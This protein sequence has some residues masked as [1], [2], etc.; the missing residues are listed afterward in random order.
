[1][2]QQTIRGQS[3]AIVAGISGN[4]MEWYDFSVYGYFAAIIGR[5]FFPTGDRTTS[6]IAAFGVFAAGFF[7]RPLG[8]ILFG[9][10]GDKKGRK[11]ALTI[12]VGMMAVPTFLIGVLP[13]Y[14]QIGLW[15]SL[16]LVLVRLLQG[17]SVGGEFTTSAIFLVEGSAAGRRGFLGSFAPL[18]ASAGT[19]LG[20][21]IGAAVTTLLGQSSIESWGW[22]IPFLIGIFVGVVGLYIRSGLVEDRLARPRT[23]SPVREAFQTEWRTILRLIGLNAAF[24]V[25][26]YM[27][28]VYVTTYIRQVDHIAQSTALDINTVAMLVTLV[29]IPLIGILSDCIGR[30]PILLVATGGL[31]VLAWPLFWMLHHPEIA[32]VLAAQIGFAVLVACF[33]GT[34]PTAMVELVPDRV[35]C[36]VL[37]VGYNTGMAFLGGVTPVVA[38]YT[39]QRSQYDLSPAFLLM[40]AAAVSFVVIAGLRETYKLVL[41]SPATVADAA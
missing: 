6:L 7:M 31:F 1:M 39:I 40:A 18:G 9:Y 35:R 4:V 8:S 14:Q 3:R 28:F 37:S 21:A 25:S 29:L 32:L 30:K 19:L 34:V 33:G 23:K 41:S 11:L 24:A 13:T 5:N 15:A 22:R 12:S 36:T 20:S 2:D 17:L 38:V 26:F 27:G 10:I 16:S